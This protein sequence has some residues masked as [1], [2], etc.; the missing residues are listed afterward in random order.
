[1]ATNVAFT[2]G[3]PYIMNFNPL[4][5]VTTDTHTCTL[6]PAFHFSA[7]SQMVNYNVLTLDI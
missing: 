5:Y 4:L 6:K 3:H 1:M 7:L 2:N